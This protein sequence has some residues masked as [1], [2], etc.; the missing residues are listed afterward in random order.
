[1]S[2]ESHPAEVLRLP[3]GYNP[4]VTPIA[5]LERLDVEVPEAV[6][7]DQTEITFYAGA[8]QWKVTAIDRNNRI[9]HLLPKHG[10]ARHKPNA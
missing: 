10:S 8:D 9:V 5:L 1:M 4:V 6:K 7:L 2:T 3:T